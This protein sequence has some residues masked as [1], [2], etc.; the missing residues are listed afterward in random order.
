MDGVFDVLNNY[1]KK[2]IT[3]AAAVEQLQSLAAS[4]DQAHLE[5]SLVD[6]LWALSSSAES[7]SSMFIELIRALIAAKLISESTALACL[8]NEQLAAI[9]LVS[10]A[11]DFHKRVRQRIACILTARVC[12]VARQSRCVC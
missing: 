5:L 3:A 8:E 11:A 6:C 12:C 1:N 10:S 2:S 7:D 4:V 9:G